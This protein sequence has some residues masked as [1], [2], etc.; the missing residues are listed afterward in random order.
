MDQMDWNRAGLKEGNGDPGYDPNLQMFKQHTPPPEVIEKHQRFLRSYFAKRRP[1]AAK[2][3]EMRQADPEA[4][5]A[6]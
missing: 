6:A 3:I 5:E 4:K 1:D 2:R